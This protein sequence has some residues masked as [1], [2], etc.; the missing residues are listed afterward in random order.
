MRRWL[1]KMRASLADHPVEI[2]FG[3]LAAVA[4]IDVI[5]MTSDLYYFVDDWRVLHLSGSLSH[6]LQPYNQSL[7]LFSFANDRALAEVFGMD[8]TAERIEAMVVL[9]AVPI[10][11]FATTRRFFTAPVAAV[12]ALPLLFY[13]MFVSLNPGELN[14]NVALL[15]AVLVAAALNRGPRADWILAAALLLALSAAG[16]GVAVVAACIVHCVCSRAPLRRWTAVLVPAVLYSAWW[17][18]E[19]G[20]TTNLGPLAMTTGQTARFVRDLSYVPFQSAALGNTVLTWILIVAFGVYACVT[21]TRGLRRSANLIAWCVGVVAWGLGLVNSRGV[22]LSVTTFRYR[23]FALGF[24]LLSI[25]PRD[26]VRWPALRAVVA[27]RRYA[28]VAAAALLLLGVARGLAVRDDLHDSA[29]QLG[30]YGRASRASAFVLALGPHV[31][32]DD[33]RLPLGGLRAAQVRGLFT[34]YG[35]SPPID[36]RSVDGVVARLGAPSS[37]TGD[38]ADGSLCPPGGADSCDAVEP[39]WYPPPCCREAVVSEDELSARG[40]TLRSRLGPPP[41]GAEGEAR[42]RCPPGLLLDGSMGDQGHGGVSCG[43]KHDIDDLHRPLPPS[44][45]SLDSGVEVE[46]KSAPAAGRARSCG[47]QRACS[48]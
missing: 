31:V 35:P 14:H 20:E 24:V 32:A 26:Q 48:S 43:M 4:L 28:Y 25:V 38:A 21:L 6:F 3:L 34:R 22:Y 19:V 46:S 15:C 47:T 30:A 7:S 2:V 41:N 42:V 37:S 8:Y 39:E 23:Y 12:F 27:N 33:A 18:I 17:L 5:R 36:R 44:G 40:A 11:Y 1:T 13:G 45:K 16:G 9:V 10:A 29:A